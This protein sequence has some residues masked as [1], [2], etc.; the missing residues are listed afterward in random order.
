MEIKGANAPFI[1]LKF[2]GK[3]I[4]QIKILFDF[5]DTDKTFLIIIM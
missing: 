2:V 1:L 3:F 5:K 4:L